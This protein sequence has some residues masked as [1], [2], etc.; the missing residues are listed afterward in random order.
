MH[1][2][3]EE[4]TSKKKRKKKRNLLPSYHAHNQLDT[5]LKDKAFVDEGSLYKYN[6]L[7]LVFVSCN[8][9]LNTRIM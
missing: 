2:T 6:Q 9:N 7:L 8:V 3:E 1:V 4:V 5:S